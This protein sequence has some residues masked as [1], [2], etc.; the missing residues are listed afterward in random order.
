VFTS[1]TTESTRSESTIN[2]NPRWGVSDRAGGRSPWSEAPSFGKSIFAYAPR[3]HKAV[4]EAA[5]FVRTAWDALG[6]KGV[7]L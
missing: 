6:A 4:R 5:Q 2:N 3:Q 1:S 7:T